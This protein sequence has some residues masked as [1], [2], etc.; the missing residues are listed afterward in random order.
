MK[1]EPVRDVRR[2]RPGPMES[3]GRRRRP[4]PG[5]PGDRGPSSPA[6][7]SAATDDLRMVGV[8]EADR[9]VVYAYWLRAARQ[10]GLRD[11]VVL[12]VNPSAVE[13][14]GRLWFLGHLLAEPI[15]SLPGERVPARRPR[16]HPLGSGR[17][18]RRGR[19]TAH[20]RRRRRDGR[21]APHH[22]DRRRPG[23]TVPALLRPDGRRPAETD[24]LDG[25][26][27][28]GPDRRA[29]PPAGVPAGDRRG[30]GGVRAATGRADVS[31]GRTPTAWRRSWRPPARG[32]LP[33]GSCTRAT[34]SRA[35]PCAGRARACG[36]CTT[37]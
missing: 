37:T 4:R 36:R 2:Q 10:P 30:R 1:T 22:A 15:N 19:R 23:G 14:D 18:V 33:R 6:W 24:R 12:R 7:S 11:T 32:R 5:P 34:C 3:R 8:A 21:P 28:A 13:E 27:P 9:S 29:G 16:R 31:G 25:A 17:H 35:R 26:R 20:L